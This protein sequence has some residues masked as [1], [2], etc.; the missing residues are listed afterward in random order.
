[1]DSATP[2]HLSNV[3]AVA[4]DGELRYIT[5]RLLMK[6]FGNKM[7]PADCEDVFQDIFVKLIE[8]PALLE[9]LRTSNMRG[10]FYTCACN[11][12]ID[13]L[14]SSPFTKWA[15][16]AQ[17]SVPVGRE[18]E[19]ANIEAERAIDTEIALDLLEQVAEIENPRHRQAAE[20]RLSGY[21]VPEIAVTMG[22]SLP[23][24]KNLVLR[25]KAKVQWPLDRDLPV[26]SQP[27]LEMAA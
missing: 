10:F 7:Q 4:A 15:K 9:Q 19:L 16:V 2:P 11:R 14:R 21:T 5:M 12:A 24:A 18:I 3:Q 20:M 23:A 1:M 27:D 26:L 8:R 17:H 13:Y 25:A 22:T 6:R